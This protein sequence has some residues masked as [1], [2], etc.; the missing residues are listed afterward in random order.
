MEFL[1]V[2][3]FQE[4]EEDEEVEKTV[5]PKDSKK[6]K[7]LGRRSTRTRKHIS[8]RWGQ[9]V[10]AAAWRHPVSFRRNICFVF[11]F[12]DGYVELGLRFTSVGGCRRVRV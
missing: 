4:G 1:L 10:D 7:N 6:S 12:D 11:I 3:V 5:K 2:H 8:Y 9:E